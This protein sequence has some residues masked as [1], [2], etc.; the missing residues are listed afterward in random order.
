MTQELIYVNA[1]AVFVLLIILGSF[2]K[3]SDLRT[4]LSK[5]FA[6]LSLMTLAILLSDTLHEIAGNMTAFPGWLFIVLSTIVFILPPAIALTWLYLTGFF[7]E[8][9]KPGSQWVVLLMH[10]P[11]AVGTVIALTSPF[12]GL[13]FTTGSGNT[14]ARGPLYMLH[15]AIVY[16]YLLAAFINI[17]TYRRLVRRD[18]YYSLLFFA[19]PP[20]VVGF[21]QAFFE[22]APF[23]WAALVLSL[24]MVYLFVLANQA[25]TDYLTRLFNRREYEKKLRTYMKAT[26]KHRRFGVALLDLD[27]FKDINDVYGHGVGDDALRTMA[28]ALRATFDK[29][30][31]TI[32][33]VGGDEFTVISLLDEDKSAEVMRARIDTTL[34]ALNRK[35]VFPFELKASVSVLEYDKDKTPDFD[36]FLRLL[37]DKLYLHKDEKRRV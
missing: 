5:A 33:R 29:P 25:N 32:A 21:I 17:I 12:T 20:G 35:A 9:K 18:H 26:V 1:F 24:L 2:I 23:T 36:Q 3:N 14:Y 15:I 28:K 30:T 34:K 31:D 22:S 13:Y 4:P 7:L 6:T 10:L 27:G 16:G 8:Q 37:D 19:V 11:L